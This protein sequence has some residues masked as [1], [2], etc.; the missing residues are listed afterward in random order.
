MNPDDL[1]YCKRDFERIRSLDVVYNLARREITEENVRTMCMC[2]AAIGGETDVLRVLMDAHEIPVTKK[3]HHLS[4]NVS[5]VF[6]VGFARRV[7]DRYGESHYLTQLCILVA[8]SY[9]WR[10]RGFWHRILFEEP[11]FASKPNVGMVHMS[12]TV[13]MVDYY[14]A[15]SVLMD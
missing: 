7:K 3:R 5:V 13:G 11:M 14:G 4:F 6:L 10:H 9:A 8:Q 15:T 12:D 1:Y 2:F